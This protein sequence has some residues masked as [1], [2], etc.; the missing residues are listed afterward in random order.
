VAREDNILQGINN[1][2][3]PPWESTG[4]LYMQTGPLGKVQDLHGCRPDPSDVVRTPLRGVRATHDGVPGF[5]D[6]EYLGL[7]KDQEG[8][9][10]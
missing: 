5:W 1:G 10:S 2:S 3:G 4:P 6:K 8:V 7:D 9:R